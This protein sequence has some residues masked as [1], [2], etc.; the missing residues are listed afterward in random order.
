MKLFPGQF[1]KSIISVYH[2]KNNLII[3]NFNEVLSR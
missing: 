3:T 1:F 2:I